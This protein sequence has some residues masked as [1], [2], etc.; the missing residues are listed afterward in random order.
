MLLMMLLCTVVSLRLAISSTTSPRGEVD[1]PRFVSFAIQLLRV[2]SALT[3]VFLS[4]SS[5]T[6]G[7]LASSH[8]VSSY[9]P[10]G[11]LAGLEVVLLVHVQELT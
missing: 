2:C 10:S 1:T 6:A 3:A 11:L 9:V 5:A 4:V 8:C 7:P